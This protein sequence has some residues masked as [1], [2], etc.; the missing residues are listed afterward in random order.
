MSVQLGGTANPDWAPSGGGASA[1]LGTHPH[2]V[3][4]QPANGWR[5]SPEN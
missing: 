2:P 5:R 3:M 4:V 1:S